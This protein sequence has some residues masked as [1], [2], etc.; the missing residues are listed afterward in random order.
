[1]KVLRLIWLG[2]LISITTAAVSCITTDSPGETA[3]PTHVALKWS[4]RDTTGPEFWAD[5]DPN[6]LLARE[7]Q[8]QSPIDIV[9]AR[10]TDTLY[11]LNFSYQPAELRLQNNGHTIQ[12]N[13]PTGSTV[14]VGSKTFALKQ[15]HFH[16]RSEHFINGQDF[17]LEMH[18]VHEAEDG[19][20][21][22]LAILF[23]IGIP[24]SFLARLA[25]HFPSSPGTIAHDPE[26]MINPLEAI[27]H[28]RGYY[29]YQG[30]LTTPPCT[31]GVQWYVFRQVH[32]L[33]AEQLK[34]FGLIYFDNRRPIQ[35]LNGRT[36]WA[37]N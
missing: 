37:K 32:Q 9:E 19:Q 35:P 6:W 7:G 27:P 15:F 5:L 17:D 25:D 18:L 20:L 1:M 13:W 23:E 22:V 2:G 24:N 34:A 8:A 31:E 10:V 28:D 16:N 33:S 36:V 12:Q 3:H 29:F 14:T 11:P 21:L 4:Y 30:S 26:H